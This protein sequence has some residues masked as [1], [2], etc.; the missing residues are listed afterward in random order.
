MSKAALDHYTRSRTHELAK[1]GI[2]INNI[3]PGFIRTAIIDRLGLPPQEVEDFYVELEKSIPMGR[4]GSS[5]EMG[6]TIAFL[7]SGDASYI[8]GVTLVADGGLSHG[9]PL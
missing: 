5:E 7:A 8:T 2:R 4:Q 9:H 3:N 6:K 1:K